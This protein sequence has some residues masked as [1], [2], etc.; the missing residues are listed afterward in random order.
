M[1]VICDMLPTQ[2]SMVVAYVP[3]WLKYSYLSELLVRYFMFISCATLI[4]DI[5]YP[6]RRLPLPIFPI[7]LMRVL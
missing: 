2:A 6:E 5:H 7:S 4:Y 1:N 3:S